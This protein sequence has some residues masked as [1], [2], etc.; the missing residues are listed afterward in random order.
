MSR[1]IPKNGNETAAV[2]G[3]KGAKRPRESL[4]ST[5]FSGSSADSVTYAP[6]AAA[7]IP[8]DVNGKQGIASAR[9]IGPLRVG[10]AFL[11]AFAFRPSFWPALCCRKPHSGQRRDRG[12]FNDLHCMSTSRRAPRARRGVVAGPACARWLTNKLPLFCTANRRLPNPSRGRSPRGNPITGRR[13]FI[14]RAAGISFA[15]LKRAGVTRRA[16][17]LAAA[18]VSRHWAN[19]VELTFQI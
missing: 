15:R 14:D 16:G 9:G 13:A 19:L 3:K 6:L 10:R 1:G 2:P 7:Q 8:D 18:R 12:C 17:P 4:G 5:I 11:S